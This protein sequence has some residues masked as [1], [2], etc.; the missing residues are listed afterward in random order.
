MIYD[1]PLIYTPAFISRN[2]W[3]KKDSPKPEPIRELELNANKKIYIFSPQS[4][5]WG[6]D[7]KPCD[8]SASHLYI[9]PR[10]GET[11]KH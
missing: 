10:L 11:S 7:N 3:G 9:K 1:I 4:L 2:V 6:R 5:S 8:L